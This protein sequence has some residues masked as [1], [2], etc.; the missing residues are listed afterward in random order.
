[1]TSVIKGRLRR[2]HLKEAKMAQSPDATEEAR[3]GPVRMLRAVFSGVGQ[4][5]LAADCFREEE[6]DRLQSETQVLTAPSEGEGPLDDEPAQP[7]LLKIT[8]NAEPPRATAKPA[9]GTKTAKTAKPSPSGSAGSTPR[10][11]AKPA[12]SP[13]RRPSRKTTAA[14]QPRFRSLDSTGN[15][16]V[17]TEQDIADL[18]E[19]NLDRTGFN[20]TGFDRPGLG[21]HRPG[22]DRNQFTRPTMTLTEVTSLPSFP[23]PAATP[24]P[25]LAGPVGDFAAQPA[26]PIAEYDGLSIASLRARLR[27][28]NPAQ[29]RE[30]AD[31]EI[32]HA[33]RADVV[34]MFENRIIKL[35]SAD[36]S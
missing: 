3:P 4:L 25:R 6:T 16:R 27:G 29:L 30:L 18:A 5:L 13:V 23:T 34:S 12:N 10:Q 32:S 9:K 28:L 33:N 2:V 19:D 31:Y 7:R 24:A 17:L 22:P 36:E 35:E 26:R 20:R 15:V 8:G 11:P 21:L 14:P 1:M